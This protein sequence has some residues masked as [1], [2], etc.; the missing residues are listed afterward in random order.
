MSTPPHLSAYLVYG[1]A[2]QTCTG[3][4]HLI[5][6]QGTRLLRDLPH[7]VDLLGYAPSER[8]L[9]GTLDT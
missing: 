8:F 1:R 7:M 5:E 4:I 2:D 9:Q 6:S 3:S